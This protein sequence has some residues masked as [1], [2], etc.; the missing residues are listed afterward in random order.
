MAPTQRPDTF[1]ITG[2]IRKD[3]ILADVPAFLCYAYIS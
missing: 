3:Q 1:D 2:T